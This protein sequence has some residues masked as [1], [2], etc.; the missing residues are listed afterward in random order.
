MRLGGHR[1]GSLTTFVDGFTEEALLQVAGDSNGD[2]KV[3][4]RLFDSAGNLVSDS[5]GFKTYPA[6]LSICC[7]DGEMLLDLPADPLG[8]TQIFNGLRLDG[9]KPGP[10]T[11]SAA[12]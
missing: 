7:P 11:R 1:A 9:S 4:F 5:E 8:R 2:P 3:A 12:Q 6:G 10:A